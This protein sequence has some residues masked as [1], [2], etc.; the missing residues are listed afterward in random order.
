MLCNN[1]KLNIGG[2][3]C[4]P[5][6]TIKS[7]IILS[8][9]VP[10]ELR[11]RFIPLPCELQ[12]NNTTRNILA[13]ALVDLFDVGSTNAEGRLKIF[14][15]GG[16]T[17]LAVVLMGNPAFDASVIGVA[18][19]ASLPWSDQLAVGSGLAAEF[20]AYDRDEAIILNG[21]V[22]VSG[23]ELNFPQLEIAVKDIVKILSVSYTAPP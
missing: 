15:T 4:N 9:N 8:A 14:T 22:A 12:H 5:D 13:D 20:I 3:I 18:Q 7:P 11:R 21:D 17:L 10:V 19:G 23:A 2:V 1:G 6:G 16:I